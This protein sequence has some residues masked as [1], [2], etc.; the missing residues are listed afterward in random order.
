[1]A[2][3]LK[4]SLARIEATGQGTTAVLDAQGELLTLVLRQLA[5]IAE[6]L[7]PRG[8]DDGMPLDELLARMIRQ[9]E[10]QLRT[11]RAILDALRKLEK[12]LPRAVVAALKDA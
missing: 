7:V 11:T 5:Q 1:M 6:L 8:D 3:V 9:N 12:D 10:E 4:D 2:A